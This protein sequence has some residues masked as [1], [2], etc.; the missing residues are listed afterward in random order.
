MSNQPQTA[1]SGRGFFIWLVLAVSGFL[2][3][4]DFGTS[5][6]PPYCNGVLMS[7]GQACV[8]YYNGTTGSSSISLYSATSPNVDPA[9]QILCGVLFIVFLLSSLIY[10]GLVL[11]TA[12]KSLGGRRWQRVT[13]PLLTIFFII[14]FSSA[15]IAIS[16]L[17]VGNEP[18]RNL[19]SV[20]LL[21]A[22]LGILW[23]P[24]QR[25]GR[26]KQVNLS[27]R[28]VPKASLH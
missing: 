7:P 14:G 17:V 18:L 20:A 5:P 15:L 19:M 16:L 23:K 27:R 12:P 13:M 6:T 2:T 21:I 3:F 11:L 24:L 26:V 10:Y 22:L 1:F 4:L 25:I 8:T 9:I 28:N